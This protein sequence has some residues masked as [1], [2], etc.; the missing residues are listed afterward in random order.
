MPVKYLEQHLA[1][2]KCPVNVSYNYGCIYHSAPNTI[3]HFSICKYNW[4]TFWNSFVSFIASYMHCFL[5]LHIM[6]TSFHPFFRIHL[7]M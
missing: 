1:Y 3:L 2:S 6:L 4:L 5:K 7:D